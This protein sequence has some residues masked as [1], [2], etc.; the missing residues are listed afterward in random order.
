MAERYNSFID[1]A[2]NARLDIDYDIRVLDRGSEAV[3]LA[4]HG[5]WIEPKTSEIAE[6]SSGTVF[7]F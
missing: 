1:L 7:S 2:A 6:A 5:G 3:I 4:P